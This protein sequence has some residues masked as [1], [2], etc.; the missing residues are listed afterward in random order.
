MPIV[1]ALAEKFPRGRWLPPLA[2]TGQ[3][4]LTVYMAHVLLGMGALEAFGRL[5]GWSLEFSVA[6]AVL[7]CLAAIMFCHFWRMRYPRGPM[8]WVMCKVTG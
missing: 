6:Y 4:A 8:E 7:F 3:L 2:S 1:H 5:G